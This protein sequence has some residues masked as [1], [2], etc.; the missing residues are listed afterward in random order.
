M[1]VRLYRSV[2]LVR[3]I[4]ACSRDEFAPDQRALCA[5]IVTYFNNGEVR[6][7]SISGCVDVLQCFSPPAS[8]LAWLAARSF[9]YAC[10]AR[11]SRSMCGFF[12][13]AGCFGHDCTM[14]KLGEG[15]GRGRVAKHLPSFTCFLDRYL[16][17]SIFSALFGRWS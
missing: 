13:T 12:L 5:I 14:H 17:I 16:H 4:E 6:V 3:V 11:K 7:P 9:F 10:R 1:T 15:I 8:S 2:F